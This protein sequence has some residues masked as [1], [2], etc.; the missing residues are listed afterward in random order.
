MTNLLEINQKQIYKC[1]ACK[2]FMS[3]DNDVCSKCHFRVTEDLKTLAIDTENEEIVEEGNKFYRNIFH[4]GLGLL[5]LGL[6]SLSWDILNRSFSE[7]SVVF[8]VVG[9]IT[10]ILGAKWLLK[11]K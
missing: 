4:G 11:G 1:P 8:V 2:Q 10:A 5:I 9:A 3:S 7:F 6:L